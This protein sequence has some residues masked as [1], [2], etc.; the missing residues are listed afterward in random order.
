MNFFG[1]SRLILGSWEV[2]LMS[3][4]RETPAPGIII[5]P[6]TCFFSLTTVKV[7][8]VP[9]SIITRGQLYSSTPATAP[10]TRPVPS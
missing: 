1:G 4:S 8:A 5:P 7:V 2:R 9:I 10:T 6:T 3:A